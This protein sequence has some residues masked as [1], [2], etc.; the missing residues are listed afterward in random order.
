MS[1][2][3]KRPCMN[4]GRGIGAHRV[5]RHLCSNACRVEAK[6]RQKGGGRLG[7][8]GRSPA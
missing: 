2:K 1:G 4:C 5:K 3:A 8:R 6:R 7:R